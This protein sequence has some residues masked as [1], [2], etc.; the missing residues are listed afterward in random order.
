VSGSDVGLEIGAE[1]PGWH[2][3]NIVAH[4]NLLVLNDKIGLGFGGYAVERGRVDHCRMLNNTL[5]CNNTLGLGSSA[6][7]G[8]IVVQFGEGNECKNNVVIVSP[9][10][11]RRALLD[12]A[13]NGNVS[14]CLDH[15]LYYCSG[16][17][18]RFDWRGVVY[19]TFAGYTNAPG[20]GEQQSLNEDPAVVS[21]ALPDL[22]LTAAS[23]AI[24]RGDPAVALPPD[25]RDFDGQPR[26]HG[27]QIDMGALAYVPEPSWWS[28]LIALVARLRALTSRRQMRYH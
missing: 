27:G 21:L 28:A 22:H 25:A 8:E 23:V 16:G 14:N 7:H 1:N 4:S 24:N 20:S 17:P 12:A 6:F 15:N 5:F 3:S 2:A 19:T 10:T 9:V 26:R 11:D 13:E 18:P